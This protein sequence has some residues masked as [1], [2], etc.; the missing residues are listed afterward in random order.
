MYQLTYIDLIVAA[1]PALIVVI[2]LIKWELEAKT[3]IYALSRMLLQLLV[4]GFFLSYIFKSDSFLIVLSVLALMLFV[5]SWI[6]LRTVESKRLALYSKA[7]LSSLIGGGATLILITQVSMQIQP[8][9]QAQVL[10]PLAGMIFA[11]TMNAVSIAAE[12]LESELERAL[13]YTQARRI[14]FKAAMIPVIN[15]LFAVGVVSLPGMMTG[16]I[17]SGISPFV[18]ARYQ[19]MVMLM[20]FGATGISAICYL[21]LHGR[22]KQIEVA[23]SIE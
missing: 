10:I 22:K 15:S 17:L 14:A 2:L 9:Y 7:L 6:A 5:S 21:Y 18:A 11:S 3:A 19:I 12:R 13:E 4:V 20:L 1:I 23:S 8:W 16:Q